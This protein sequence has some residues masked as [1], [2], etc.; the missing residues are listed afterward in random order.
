MKAHAR[1]VAEEIHSAFD[2]NEVPLDIASPENLTLIDLAIDGEEHDECEDWTSKLGINL[3]HCVNARIN[4]PSKQ[5]PWTLALGMLFSDKHPGLEFLS[6][7]WQS[8]RSR[9]KRLNHSAQTKTCDS[10]QRKK[11]DQLEGRIDGSTAKKKLIQYSR[12][13]FKSKQSCSS[14]ASMVHKFQEKSANVSAV[15]SGEHRNCVSINELDTGNFRSDCALSAKSASTAMSPVHHEIQVTE[16]PISMSLKTTTP[17]LSNSFPDHNATERNIEM[18]RKN[19]ITEAIIIGSDG[20]SLGLDDEVHQ[21]YQSTCKSNNEEAALSTVSL[22]NQPTLASMDGSFESPNNNYAAEKNSNG[23]SLKETTEQKIISLSERDKEPVSD[24]KPIN[25]HTLN[26]EVCEVPREL[27]A[28]ADFHDT[29]IMD[30]EKQQETHVSA[31]QC[32][33]FTRGEC[34][35]G[36]NEVISVS[37]KQCQVQNQSKINEEHVSKED[38]CI[39]FV[40]DKEKELE[41]QPINRSDEELCSGTETSFKESSASIQE[42]SK[43]EKETCVGENVNGS[44]V[45]LLQD[46]RGLESSELTTAVLRSK[47]GKKRKREVEQITKNQSD[48]SNFI[49]SPCERLRP[50]AGKI[51]AGKSGGDINQDDTENQE[52]RRA[53]RVMAPRKDKKDDVKKPHKCD[54]DGCH[55]SFKTKADLLLHKRNICPHKGCGKKFRSHKYTQLHERVHDDERPLMCPWKGCSMSFKWAWARTEHIRVH[56]GEKPYHCKVEGC[57]LS[58]RFVSDFSRHRRKTGHMRNLLLEI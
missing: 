48:C 4:S 39:Q 41:I 25:E 30:A 18:F 37:V 33:E 40:S 2:Y 34:A 29:V 42:C 10:N 32:C 44:E 50:R 3:R 56:T 47:A 24:D 55:M 20:N 13:K 21:E 8:R 36:L 58:F 6:L 27:Y 17:Q 9:S 51:M 57:G 15:L 53:R 28:A 54:L 14:G 43:I 45:H 1:A 31:K 19:Q 22:V 16:V 7:N 26:G 5:V 12:R 49:R 11:D 35:E 46:N 52:A 38:S 23:M